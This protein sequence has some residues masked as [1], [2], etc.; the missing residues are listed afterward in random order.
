M[1]QGFIPLVILALAVAFAFYR[2]KTT[3]FECP[4]CGCW[5]KVS[6]FIF[7]FTFHMG[8]NRYVTCPNCHKGAMMSPIPDGKE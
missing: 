8:F 3:H 1:A 7:A 6:G 4:T 2:A 5:F